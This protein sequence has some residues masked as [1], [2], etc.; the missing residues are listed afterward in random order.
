MA[1]SAPRSTDTRDGVLCGLGAYVLWGVFPV[2]FK[3]VEEV[4]A[5]EVLLHR[6]IW[7]VPFG[8][9][10]LSVRGQWRELRDALR[11]LRNLR[12][13]MLSALCITWNWFIYI[14]AVVNERIFETSLGYY[15]NPLI[16]VL[17][18]VVLFHERLRRLQ[19]LAV[20]LASIGVLVLILQ[21]GVVPWVSLSLAA[22]FT[23]YGVIRK[24]VPIGA[25]PGLFVETVLLFPIAAGALLWLMLTQQAAFPGA[26]GSTQALLMLAGPVTVV[27]LLLFAI[28]TRRLFLTTIGFMQFL[29][30]T[31]Q[32][33]TA[34][35]FGEELGAARVFCFA[36]IWAA[37]L[38]FSVDALRAGQ[39]QRR[40][41]R[42]A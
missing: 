35:Y 8:A 34:V 26:G 32:F 33:I 18:G 27:P 37:V 38:V 39:R 19:M 13:L 2:Y 21:G 28:A 12:W 4:A 1:E 7:A 16:Y 10:I 11:D 9:L 23:A 25:M 6:I 24:Q 22:S 17:V 30:P 36:F 20:L 41:L 14:W 5:G 40:A 29:A 3:L 15:I 31:L 42:S